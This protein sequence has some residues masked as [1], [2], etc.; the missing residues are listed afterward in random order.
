MDKN[1]IPNMKNM[2]EEEKKAWNEKIQ[3]FYGDSSK[4]HMVKTVNQY[5]GWIF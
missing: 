1:K 3:S 5:R 2:S 4:T